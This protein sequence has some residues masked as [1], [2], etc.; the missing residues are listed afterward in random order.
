MPIKLLQHKSWHVYKKDNVE[1]VRRDEEE[2]QRRLKA[3][4][5]IERTKEYSEVVGSLRGEKRK[6]VEPHKAEQNECPRQRRPRTASKTRIKSTEDDQL[7]K[8]SEFVSTIANDNLSNLQFRSVSRTPWYAD[9]DKSMKDTSTRNPSTLP[10]DPLVVMQKSLARKRQL[11][12]Q[13][14]EI[15]RGPADDGFEDRYTH[16]PSKGYKD[17]YVP[18]QE[19][20]IKVRTRH[21]SGSRHPRAR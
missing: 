8:T 20:Q 2:E 16:L 12:E 4:E 19:E 11:Q 14:N 3:A 5:K 18:N 21:P 15:R 1:R 17:V 10:G 7:P 9:Q 13:K 6:R